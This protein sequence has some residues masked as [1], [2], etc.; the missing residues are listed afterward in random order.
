MRVM[1]YYVQLTFGLEGCI[2]TTVFSCM[3]TQD[4]HRHLCA[5]RHQRIICNLHA[6]DNYNFSVCAL[7]FLKKYKIKLVT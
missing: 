2:K 7:S 5:H 4:S 6:A 3:N 1:S